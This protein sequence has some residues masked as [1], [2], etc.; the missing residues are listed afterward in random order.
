[1]GTLGC[2][3]DII[4]L[5]ILKIT[6]N[7]IKHVFLMLFMMGNFSLPVDD[8]SSSYLIFKIDFFMTDSYRK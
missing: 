2:A 1:M 4:V 8:R 3:Y 7:Y 5:Y 6:L